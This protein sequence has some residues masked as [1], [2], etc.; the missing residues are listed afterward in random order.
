V[1]FTH[2]ADNIYPADVDFVTCVYDTR[3]VLINSQSNTMRTQYDAAK[4]QAVLRGGMLF[5]QRISVPE[6]GFYFLR[7][8]V[9]DNTN[10]RV[11]A[12]ELPV[13]SVA[14]LPPLPAEGVPAAGG[15]R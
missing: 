15:G 2:G 1:A 12:I 4:L 8:I 7:V 3:G 13:S 9:H 5:D 14:G 10:G 6:K 11:G